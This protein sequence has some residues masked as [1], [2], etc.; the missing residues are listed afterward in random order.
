M[1]NLRYYNTVFLVID[2]VDNAI[3][4]SAN[5]IKILIIP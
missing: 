2:L 1:G 3:I 5:S 4:S